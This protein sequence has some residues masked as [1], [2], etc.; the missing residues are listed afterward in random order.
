MN[1]KIDLVHIGP[2][3]SG[4]TW[5][6]ECLKEHPE[7]QVPKNDSVHYFDIFYPLGQEWLSNH[8]SNN[9]EHKIRVDMTPSYLRDQLALERIAKH[10][11]KNGVALCLRNPIERAFSHYWHEKKKERFHYQFEEI[12]ENYDL[13]S[14]WM[15]PGLYSQTIRDCHNLFGRDHVLVQ[16]FD[17]LKENPNKF[18]QEFL[19]FANLDV[20]FKPSVI[21]KKV[22]T[23]KPKMTSRARTN[24][25]RLRKLLES[26]G[27]LKFAQNYR[28]AFEELPGMGMRKGPTEK[29][30]DLDSNFIE[31]LNSLISDEIMDLQELLQR[32]LSHWFLDKD[33]T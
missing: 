23:A 12:I 33:K 27:T 18:L 22:N 24:R 11:P 13:W 10:N 19:E 25:K 21:D 9:E 28:S 2:Q 1:V 3:K 31:H 32:D 8:Y 6:Y 17:D 29:L 26:T 15:K 5:L 14:N 30:S 4:T 16:Y 20:N 7:C